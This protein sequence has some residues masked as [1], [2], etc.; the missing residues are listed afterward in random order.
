MR[1]DLRF[2]AVKSR[3]GGG[4]ER[5]R[6]KIVS[7]ISLVAVVGLKESKKKKKNGIR[8][9]FLLYVYTHTENRIAVYERRATSSAFY[10]SFRIECKKTKSITNMVNGEEVT[11]LPFAWA[12]TVPNWPDSTEDSATRRWSVS[13]CRSPL[14]ATAVDSATPGTVPRLWP[15]TIPVCDL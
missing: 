7:R 13:D 3:W 14:A 10:V 6:K 8:D 9:G 12:K 4:K 15:P 11:L 5:K 2:N 1:I